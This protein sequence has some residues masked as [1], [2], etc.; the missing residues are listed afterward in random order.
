M[1]KTF[2]VEGMHCSS[3]EEIIK[4]SLADLPGITH[5]EVSSKKGIVCVE[6]DHRTNEGKIREIIEKEGYEVRK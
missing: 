6:F 3:C 1:K 5:S 2:T 4:D